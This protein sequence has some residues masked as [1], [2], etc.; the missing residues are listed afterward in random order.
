MY[1]FWITCFVIKYFSL[2]SNIII[3]KNIYYTD[4]N[5]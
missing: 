1:D 5:Y 3:P 2:D 4:K